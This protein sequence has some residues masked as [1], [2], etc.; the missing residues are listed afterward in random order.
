V[1][2]PST[3]SAERYYKL[4]DSMSCLTVWLSSTTVG[5]INVSSCLSQ[6]V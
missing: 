5:L 6:W 4:L 2:D 1:Y 3:P